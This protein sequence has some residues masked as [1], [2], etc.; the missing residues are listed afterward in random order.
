MPSSV[1]YNSSGVFVRSPAPNAVTAAAGRRIDDNFKQ[2]VDR[3]DT[4]AA[5]TAAHGATG[6][7][8]GTTNAQTLT[9]KTISGASNTIT[10]V[11]DSALSSNIPLKNAANTFVA[12]Q[13]ITDTVR[14][15]ATNTD[16]AGVGSGVFLYGAPSTAHEAAGNKPRIESIIID[17]AA[18]TSWGFRPY[19]GFTGTTPLVLTITSSGISTA[20]NSSV[21]GTFR[22]GVYTAGT[23][24]TAGIAGRNAFISD[25]SPA[26][27]VWDDGAQWI[28]ADGTAV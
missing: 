20:G 1:N 27:P 14:L 5:L 12:D 16:P 23:L 7:V 19:D 8:V 11:P 10:N 21:S 25:G 17:S 13:K 4:H 2:L 26:R 15:V 24:P 28:Y 9:N 22:C 3:G 18:N 6:A